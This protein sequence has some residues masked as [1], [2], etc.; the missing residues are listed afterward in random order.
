MV[1]SSIKAVYAALFGN[2]GIFIAKLIVAIVTGSIAMF[3][4]TLHF[5]SDTFNRLLFLFGFC[6]LSRIS[7]QEVGHSS[8]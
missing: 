7:F 8:S 4:E 1:R 5:V 2:L 3:A 6:L